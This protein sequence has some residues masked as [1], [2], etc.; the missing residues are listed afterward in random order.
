MS[1]RIDIA[2]L[3]RRDAFCADLGIELVE[4]SLGRAVTRVTIAPR[5]LNF[6][7]ACHGGLTFTLADAAFGFASNS[8]G[9]AAFSIDSHMVHNRAAKAGDVLT[10]TAVEISRSSKLSHY[11]VDV[12]RDDGKLVAGLTGTAFASGQALEDLS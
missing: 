8:H 4:A 11:R 10:A 2:A 7:G 3:A 1:A 5:H 9:K 12:V 6:L